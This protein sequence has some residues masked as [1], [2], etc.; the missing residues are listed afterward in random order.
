MA[1]GRGD[2]DVDGDG[3]GLAETIGTEADVELG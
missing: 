1:I 3:R 2:L